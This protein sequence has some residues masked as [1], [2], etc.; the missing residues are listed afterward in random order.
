[1]SFPEYLLYQVLAGI[2]N[3]AIYGLM[4]LALV[5]IHQAT[6]HVNFAQGEMAMF[7]TFIAWSLLEA[8]L[9]YWATFGV[10]L[11]GSFLAGL[12]IQRWLLAPLARAPVLSH[13]T[14]F[15]GLLLILH[16]LAGA[17]FDHTLKTFPSPFAQQTWYASPYLSAHGAGTLLVMAGVS[18]AL[19]VLFRLTR[20][21]LAMRA[22]AL[23]PDSA[24]LMGVRVDRMLAL[25]WGLAAAIG[26]VAGMLIAPVVYLDPNMM[27]SILLYGFAAALA[28]GLDNPWG[29]L[30]GGI[31][32]GVLENLLGAFVIGTEFKLSAALLLIVL[33]LL[34]RPQGLFGRRVV[35]RV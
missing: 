19:F 22:A 11:V 10:T 30:P 7:S 26:A 17:L 4:A 8:G 20:I 5:V 21:G 34:L 12:L 24:R 3:G 16:A 35:S 29:A 27:T 15:I 23:D 31:L 28:G 32:V 1:M 13:V 25:G 33:A 9:P 6:H 14:V 2:A 18:L